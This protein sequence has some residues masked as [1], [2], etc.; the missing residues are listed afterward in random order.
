VKREGRRKQVT[1]RRQIQARVRRRPQ[2]HAVPC[3]VEAPVAASDVEG[4]RHH[5][6]L[7]QTALQKKIK[8]NQ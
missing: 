5:S 7:R 2:I 4:I 6:D 1:W 3:A 8:E